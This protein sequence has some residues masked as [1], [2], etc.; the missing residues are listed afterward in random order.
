MAIITNWYT[1]DN[2]LG[3]N[4]NQPQTISTT[5]NPD[6][7][8]ANF[9]LGDRCQGNNGSEW[10]FVQ[11]SATVTANN[12]VAISNEFKA[13]CLTSALIASQLYSYGVAE[14]QASAAA[15]SDYFWALL[16]ANG[17]VA[18]N[19]V[20]STSTGSF[21]FIAGTAGM[22]TS[23]VTSDALMNIVPVSATITTS[24]SGPME[25]VIRSYIQPALNML[26]AGA[27]A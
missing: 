13:V 17:G 24:A 16:K 8:A 11:A 12:L 7:P 1:V 23:S 2:K 9:A 5:T 14:F 21:V 26:V 4:L 20:A 10:V 22:I 27:T 18:V 25:C 15:T 6:Y 19:A 3:A